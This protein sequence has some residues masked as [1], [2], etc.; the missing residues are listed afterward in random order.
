MFHRTKLRASANSASAFLIPTGLHEPGFDSWSQAGRAIEAAHRVPA[1]MSQ[2]VR[3]AVVLALI[4]AAR[5]CS[6]GMLR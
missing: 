3:T 5:I 1:P 4:T 6:T 2:A